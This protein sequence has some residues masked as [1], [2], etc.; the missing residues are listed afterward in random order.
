MCLG[1][2]GE[3]RFPFGYSLLRIRSPFT[4]A[5][6]W[7]DIGDQDVS[8]AEGAD[9]FTNLM[10]KHL[11]VL[12]KQCL[13]SI[14]NNALFQ[15][16]FQMIGGSGGWSWCFCRELQADHTDLLLSK[17]MTKILARRISTAVEPSC[18]LGPE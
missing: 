16:V 14:Y 13:L 17:L 9:G 4:I 10:I 5:E 11:L 18:L 3:G 1:S 7:M 15:A 12:G 2:S 8:K 6:L